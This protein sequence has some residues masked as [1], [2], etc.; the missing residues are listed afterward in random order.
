MKQYIKSIVFLFFICIA[1]NY[2]AQTKST[3]EDNATVYIVRTSILGKLIPFDHYVDSSYVGTFTHGKYIKLK[4]EPGKH[5][6]WA[7]SINKS[8]VDADI[9]AG[10]TYVILS[11]PRMGAL[12][13][14]VKLV[15]KNEPTKSEL[16]IIKNYIRKK[17]KV[18]EKDVRTDLGDGKWLKKVV[19]ES[20]KEYKKLK[21]KGKEIELLSKAIDFSDILDE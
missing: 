16:E 10:K 20:M 19:E 4:I 14:R 18:S 13:A 6:I 8:F 1:N 7:T 9:E 11:D 17:E 3:V 12:L 21:K 2:S 15:P 5:L